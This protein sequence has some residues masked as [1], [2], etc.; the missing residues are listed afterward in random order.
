MLELIW[1]KMESKTNPFSNQSSSFNLWLLLIEEILKHGLWLQLQH[2]QE[3]H[4][5][6]PR[7]NK[8]QSTNISNQLPKHLQ[9]KFQH[10]ISQT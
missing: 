3:P 10:T 7:L 5:S 2:D 6:S 1:L 9:F 4:N 8:T